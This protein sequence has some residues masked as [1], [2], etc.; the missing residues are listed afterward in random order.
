MST[1]AEATR[2]VL[3][4]VLESDA[5]RL[6]VANAELAEPGFLLTAARAAEI[7]TICRSLEGLPL[8]I[9]LAA[10]RSAERSLVAIATELPAQ[11]SGQEAGEGAA[12]SLRASLEWSYGLLREPEQKL[13]RRLGVLS[14]ALPDDVLALA[15]PGEDETAVGSS[16]ERLVSLGLINAEEDLLLGLTHFRTA[17]AVRAYARRLLDEAGESGAVLALHLECFTELARRAGGLLA[18]VR[19]RRVLALAGAN[20]RTAFAHAIEA[21]D[22]R[23]LEMCGSLV[24][25][26]FASDRFSEGREAREQAV[27]RFS[28]ADPATRAVALRSGALL[29]IATEDYEAGYAMAA[30]GLEM[31]QASGDRRA[32]GLAMGTMNLV[33]ATVDPAAAAQNG[34]RAVELLRDSG[35]GHDLAH[36]LLTQAVAEALRDRPQAFDS[37]RAELGGL[38]SARGDDW[39]LVIVE[40]HAAWTRIVQGHP[41]AALEEARRA[42]GRVDGERSTRAALATAHE[43][44]ARALQG[45]AERALTDGLDALA[46]ARAADAEVAALSLEVAIAFARLALGQ[47]DAVE[48]AALGS[49]EAPALHAVVF[50][51]EALARIALERGQIV[52][53]TAHALAIRVVARRSGSHRAAA[54][55]DQIDGCCALARGELDEATELLHT[56]LLEQSR[57]GCDRDA[58]E[59]LEALGRLAGAAGDAR[60]AVRLLAAAGAA[61]RELGIVRVPP[62]AARAT[63]ERKR[64]LGILSERERAEALAAGQRLSLAEA[65]AFARRSRGRRERAGDGWA[66]LTPAEAQAAE[67][68]AA[69]ATNPEIASRLL[70]SRSTVKTHLSRAYGKLGVSNRTELAARYADIGERG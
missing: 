63:A 1:P 13:F 68:A 9:G 65:I 19:G 54:L 44:H 55:A 47:L 35:S 26:W 20:L 30:D 5:G 61:R 49:L 66:S 36:A 34:A 51:R 46:A 29:A 27:A 58:A 57:A 69:G 3:A 31:A 48:S 42:G 37:L 43:L 52:E 24:Y 2:S 14:G 17:P 33:L 10:A 18:D 38:P 70:M 7:G 22:P 23:A 60:R 62:E 8:A 11:L 16:L 4:E 59:C 67:L 50:W 41:R 39:L 56:S 25:W 6:F 12:G 28:D 53:A 64:L 15:A 32:T 45:E 21:G 40:L